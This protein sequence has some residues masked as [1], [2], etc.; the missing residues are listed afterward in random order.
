MLL[1]DQ[2]N[3]QGQNRPGQN[4]LQASGALTYNDF[5]YVT[6]KA[7]RS[8]D[9]IQSPQ[10]NGTETIKQLRNYKNITNAAYYRAA[11]ISFIENGLF[12]D[13]EFDPTAP[14]ARYQLATVLANIV[15]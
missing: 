15:K 2:Q 13:L 1:S 11:F 3:A 8:I 12:F 7:L 6:Y 9:R 10:S 5:V 14:A 4:T